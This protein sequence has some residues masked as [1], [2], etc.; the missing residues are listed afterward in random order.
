MDDFIE[1][2]K[3]ISRKAKASENNKISD[4]E[5]NEALNIL[6]NIASSG[7]NNFSE[8]SAYPIRLHRLHSDLVSLLFNFQ[9]Y[10]SGFAVKT[11][12]KFSFVIQSKS[13]I[14]IYGLASKDGSQVKQSMHRTIQLLSLRYEK[15]KDEITFYDSTNKIINP[16]DVVLQVIKWGIS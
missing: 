6:F 15:I 11:R 14:F 16:Q 3:T 9:D 2:I 12:K 8:N 13:N 4:A 10:C 5:N 7:V 1:E